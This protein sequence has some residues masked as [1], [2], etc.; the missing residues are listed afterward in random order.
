MGVSYNGS[1]NHM[2][3]NLVEDIYAR[4]PAYPPTTH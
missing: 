1:T 4:F 2:F 3:G